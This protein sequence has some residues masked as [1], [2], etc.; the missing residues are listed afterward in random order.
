MS[1]TIRIKKVLLSSGT[2]VVID[3]E[4]FN[5]TS[6]AWGKH[7]IEECE[8]ALDS[9]QG[10]LD[11]LKPLVR[12]YREEGP[13]GVTKYK[14][15]ALSFFY[16]KTET[17][18]AEACY[19]VMIAAHRNLDQWGPANCNTSRLFVTTEDE[20]AECV[21]TGEA[22]L[23]DE[24]AI[25]AIRYINGERK[26]V[27]MEFEEAPSTEGEIEFPDDDVVNVEGEFQ[28]VGDEGGE[29]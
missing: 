22:Q 29:G 10:S 3:W 4:E 19:K 20:D 8:P 13:I 25:E 15:T 7:S 21:S 27:T 12:K 26:Q 5:E 11:A 18:G 28:V 9:L 14:V 17:P 6:R 2:D 16:S 23:I 1:A 24:V